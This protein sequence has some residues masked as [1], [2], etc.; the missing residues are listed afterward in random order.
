RLPQDPAPS[1]A[2]VLRT[3]QLPDVCR[4]QER[5][6]AGEAGLFRVLCPRPADPAAWLVAAIRDGHVPPKG[7]VSK[8]ERRRREEARRAKEREDV[9]RRRRQREQAARERSLRE[10]VDAYL[11]RLTPA[12]REA[13][14]AE[15]L[16]RADPEARRACEEASPARLRAALRLGLV[17]E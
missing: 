17:R 10:E 11:E 8:A 7:F 2:A 12:G 3:A 6:A 14:E 5:P 16:A 1:P 15:A 9:E 13:M 4:A